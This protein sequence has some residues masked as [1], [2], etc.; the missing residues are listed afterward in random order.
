MNDVRSLSHS[1]W[2]CRYHIV[3][4]PKYRRQDIYGKF[5]ADI[6]K[7][8]RD[9]SERK[10][11]EIIEAECCPD[12][13]HM[14]VAIPPHMSV[15]QYMGYLKSKSSLMIFDR[16]ANLKYKYGNR[17]FCCRGCYVDT[18]GKYEGAIKEYIQNQL[19]EDIMNDQISFKEFVDT[20]TGEP[21]KQGKDKQPPSRGLPVVK[22]WLSGFSVPPL[23]GYHRR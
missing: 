7:I 20:F 14:L 13:N 8:L 16:H 17:H 9:L 18:V 10:E 1:K 23:G 19:Q 21:V 4:A 22:V 5:K 3:F 12:H 15:A 11:V 6:G 2:R